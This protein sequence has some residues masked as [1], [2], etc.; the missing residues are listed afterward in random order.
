MLIPDQGG[1]TG[2]VSVL[3]GG[4]GGTLLEPKGAYVHDGVRCSWIFAD[5]FYISALLSSSGA[6]PTLGLEQV[7]VSALSGPYEQRGDCFAASCVITVDS[8]LSEHSALNLTG[9]SNTGQGNGS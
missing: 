4:K 1:G 6:L 8:F 9:I 7:A 5:L 3:A 2:G